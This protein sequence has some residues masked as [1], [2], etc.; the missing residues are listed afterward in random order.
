MCINK[1]DDIVN[2]FNNTYHSTIKMKPSDVKWSTHVDF[3][4]QKNDKGLKFKAGDHVRTLKHGNIFAK[5]YT[6]NWTE[7]IF[8]IKKS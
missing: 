3:N 2:K 8:V 6:P 4:V 7:E 5:G 1:S